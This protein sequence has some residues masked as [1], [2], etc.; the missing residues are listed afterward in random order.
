MQMGK[1]DSRNVIFICL[2]I[3]LVE[4]TVSFPNLPSL[5]F[6]LLVPFYPFLC[7]IQV[8]SFLPL[9]SD[10]FYRKEAGQRNLSLALALCVYAAI[11]WQHRFLGHYFCCWS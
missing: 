1:W 8:H 9:S 4:E 6:S 3:F 7:F 5:S 11:K 2:S 10:F